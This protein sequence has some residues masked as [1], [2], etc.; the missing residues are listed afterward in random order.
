MPGLPVH[1]QLPEFTETHVH[2]QPAQEHPSPASSAAV[3]DWKGT[4]PQLGVWGRQTRVGGEEES[5]GVYGGSKNQT[6]GGNW[7]QGRGQ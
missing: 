3:S 2:P 7:E 6:L 4:E 1:Y 5:R